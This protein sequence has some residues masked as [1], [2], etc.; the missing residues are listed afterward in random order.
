MFEMSTVLRRIGCA[1]TASAASLL[2][3][4]PAMAGSAGGMPQGSAHKPHK[5]V[6]VTS[7]ILPQKAHKPHKVVEVTSLIL[8]QKTHKP[9]KVVSIVPVVKAPKVQKPHK[10]PVLV[11][12][13]K[14]PPSHKP[15]K[16]TKPQK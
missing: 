5:T 4:V 2:L 12:V 1:V 9:H 7:L 16:P 14:T 6:E 3:A 11:P 13:V 8:P 15:H 10:T